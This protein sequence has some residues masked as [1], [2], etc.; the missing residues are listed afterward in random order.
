MI[1]IKASEL[2][3]LIEEKIESEGD[4]D[5]CIWNHDG[6]MNATG[7]ERFIHNDDFLTILGG[8]WRD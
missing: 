5:I 4:I 7:V 1:K 6:A 3:K 8:E 2:V